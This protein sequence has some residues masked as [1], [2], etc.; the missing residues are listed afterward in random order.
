MEKEKAEVLRKTSAVIINWR[1][2]PHGQQE[3]QGGL[4]KNK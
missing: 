2:R 1:L 3:I 4:C